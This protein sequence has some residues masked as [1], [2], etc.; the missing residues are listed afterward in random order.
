MNYAKSLAEP[1]LVAL[2]GQAASFLAGGQFPV[3]V[4]SGNAVGGL[5]GTTFVPYGVQLQFTRTSPTRI[6]FV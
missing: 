5:Q 3:P 6:A 4:V 1:N 2:N